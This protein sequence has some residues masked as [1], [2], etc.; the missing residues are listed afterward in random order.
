MNEAF[1]FLFSAIFDL[2]LFMVIFTLVA[3]MRTRAD[4]YNPLSQFVVKAT[5]PVIIPLRRMLP[6]VGKV[7][8]ATVVLALLICVAKVLALSFL[9]SMMPSL[10]QLLLG[11][12]FNLLKQGMDLLFYILLAR[13]VLSW[14]S[15]GRTPLESLLSQLTEPLL[16][17]IRRLIPA[18][19]GFDFSAM[20]LIIG[21]LFLGKLLTPIYIQML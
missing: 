20:V 16:A 21:L 5:N 12:V 6:S 18:V 9:V 2:A 14:F 11:S 3:A 8:T 4:F 19:G 1:N 7:D 10:Y 15:Q 13:A 17:P